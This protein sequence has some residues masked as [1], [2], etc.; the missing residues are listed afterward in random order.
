M[1]IYTAFMTQEELNKYK[2]SLEKEKAEIEKELK[3]VPLVQDMGS[4]T[5]GNEDMSE[6]ADEA[7]QMLN[8]AAARTVLE[9]R[10]KSIEEALSK[11]E[12][13]EYQ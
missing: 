2:Q 8:N 4:D 13:G 1:V 7:E 3:A 12:K 11:I 5:E 10:L 9:E 6:E